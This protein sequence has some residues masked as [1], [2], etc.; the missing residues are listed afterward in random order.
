MACSQYS[1]D[2]PVTTSLEQSTWLARWHSSLYN[3]RCL[4]KTCALYCIGQLTTEAC[5]RCLENTECV[6]AYECVSCIK[7]DTNFDDVYKCSVD[8]QLIWW[9]I[10]LLV[11]G[12]ILFACLF[13]Y[14]YMM[15]RYNI[16]PNKTKIHMAHT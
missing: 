13:A 5:K 15:L 1:P 12:S 8:T 11:L 2:L 9:Q 7:T 16:L 10:I 6:V 3:D 14:S 4:Q